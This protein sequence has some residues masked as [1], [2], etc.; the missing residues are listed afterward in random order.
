MKYL[1]L[2]LLLSS[3]ATTTLY[4]KGELLAKFQGNGPVEY[5]DGLTS[6]KAEFN[7]S[8]PTVAGGQAVGGM[9]VAGSSL[10]LP[11]AY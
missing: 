11:L 10:L 3:C 7:H 4:R 6:L 8:K 9:V 1:L 2:L 5:T